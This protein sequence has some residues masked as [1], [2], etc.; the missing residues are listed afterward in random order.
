MYI[1][2]LHFASRMRSTSS[3]LSSQVHLWYDL[4]VQ[5]EQ[6]P[7]DALFDLSPL[8]LVGIRRG[9]TWHKKKP[10]ILPRWQSLR[11][12]TLMTHSL[13]LP[14]FETPPGR[15]HVASCTMYLLHCLFPY[16]ILLRTLLRRKIGTA[17]ILICRISLPPRF[18]PHFCPNVEA[19]RSGDT[20]IQKTQ[21]PVR[22][23]ALS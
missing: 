5:M 3:P 20:P 9:M 2:K 11:E 22:Q 19:K 4:T 18:E 7:A 12:K 1:E 14:K 10:W 16:P 13:E 6:R 15:A 17:N 21:S 8:C 23:I